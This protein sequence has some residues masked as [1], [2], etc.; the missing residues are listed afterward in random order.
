MNSIKR[1]RCGR[2]FCSSCLG[3]GFSSDRG[4]QQHLHMWL[5]SSGASRSPEKTKQLSRCGM[6]KIFY[7]FSKDVCER[8]RRGRN[9]AS[10]IKAAGDSLSEW[11]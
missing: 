4:F 3:L 8:A 9:V 11:K 7:G 6:G 5:R 1:D 2:L 10:V